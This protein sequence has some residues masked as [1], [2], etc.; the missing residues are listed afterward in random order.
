MKKRKFLLIVKCE[1]KTLYLTKEE[2]TILNGELGEAACTALRLL[3]TMGEIFNA[4][5]LIPIKSAQISGISYKTIGDAGLEFIQDFSRKGAKASVYA[6][7]NPT[8]MDLDNWKE[9]GIPEDFAT[10]QKKIISAL[11]LLDQYKFWRNLCR[12]QHITFLAVFF[13]ARQLPPT[14]WRAIAQIAIGMPGKKL[15]RL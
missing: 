11:K 1:T 13:G 4:D 14:K 10:N 3:V 8:G 2:E 15:G 6:T 12:K 9:I 7:I 5:R